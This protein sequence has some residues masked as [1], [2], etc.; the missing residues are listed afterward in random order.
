M[1]RFNL[2]SYVKTVD[3]KFREHYDGNNA[4]VASSLTR[5]TIREIFEYKYPETPWA[6][7]ELIYIDTGH[8]EG[9]T[10]VGWHEE[11]D[12]HSPGS[13]FV[14]PD[15]PAPRADIAGE[16]HLNR[17]H[18]MKVA[19]GF[20][21]QELLEYEMQGLVSDLPGRKARSARR[22][23]DNDLNGAIMSGVPSLSIT[24]VLNQPGSLQ[25][26][27]G[28]YAGTTANWV[29]AT[30]QEVVDSFEAV[31]SAIYDGSNGTLTPDTAV[32]P[33][34]VGRVLRRQNSLANGDSI[35]KWLMDSFPEI[36][37]WKVDPRMNAAGLGGSAAMLLYRR[38]KDHVRAI[39]PQLLRPMPIF[40]KGGETE[41]EFR[42]R[43]AGIA[44]PYPTNIAV[45]S[46]V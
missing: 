42:S 10:S 15:A 17:A 27:A 13:T 25:L 14:A 37:K 1:Q 22:M 36:T 8:H 16:E 11:R 29:A 31:Y 18:T 9:S 7:G 23:H 20:D 2:D 12:V 5:S 26:Q 33:G 41:Q 38:D 21:L 43:F 45:L 44:C 19:F 39:V 32:F 46:G 6:A 34:K 24:G 3:R 40:I 30:P 4:F 28:V 35:L